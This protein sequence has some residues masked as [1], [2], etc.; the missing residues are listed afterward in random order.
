MDAVSKVDRYIKDWHHFKSLSDRIYSGEIELSDYNPDESP[1]RD[2]R[3][4]YLIKMELPENILVGAKKSDEYLESDRTPDKWYCIKLYQAL[5]KANLLS[6]DDDTFYSFVYRMSRDYKGSEEPIKI[7]WLGKPREIYYLI[8]WFCKDAAS[9]MW[10][11]T[12]NFFCLPEGVKLK[13]NGVKNHTKTPTPKIAS[14]I[15]EMSK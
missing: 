15:E 14:I 11:K 1:L 5:V 10:K 12:A 6:Y 9:K 2:F 13:D 4:K 8:N 3:D 7:V